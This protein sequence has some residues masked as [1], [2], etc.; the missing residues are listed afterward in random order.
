MFTYVVG[1]LFV[2]AGANHF[3]MPMFYVNMMPN[4]LPFPLE[5]VYI[6]GVMEIVLGGGVMIPQF[7]KWSAYGLVAL[8]IAVFPANINMALHPDS[9]KDIPLWLLYA[10]LPLQFLLIWLVYRISK[11]RI[12]P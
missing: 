3:Y 7:R 2:L 4:G 9:F 1:L 12:K 6:S 10:R 11:N 8:L 5:L